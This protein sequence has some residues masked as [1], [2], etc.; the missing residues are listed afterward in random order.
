MSIAKKKQP[1]RLADEAAE[2][3]LA[4]WLSS[5]D[6]FGRHPTTVKVIYRKPVFWLGP[7]QQKCFLLQYAMPDG[8]RFVG[9][10]G[11]T[12][13][14][15]KGIPFTAIEAMF[16][17]TVNPTLLNIYAAW[18]LRNR[19]ISRHPE[20]GVVSPERLAQVKATLNSAKRHVPVN[21]ELVDYLKVKSREH[22]V[23]SGDLVYD[24]LHDAPIDDYENVSVEAHDGRPTHHGER[25]LYFHTTGRD[26]GR[27]SR[28]RPGV[29]PH[30]PLLHWLGRTY[31]PLEIGYKLG[32]GSS[33]RVRPA[34]KTRL[35]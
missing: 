3:A 32:G 22:F 13:G 20:R 26:F 9:I 6:G 27:M 24:R 21:L 31:G 33:V 35:A 23:L 2:Q 30:V 29:E 8:H 15:L 4:D 16:K 14:S 10:A 28:N 18:D 12:V 7:D 25:D 1:A 19:L 34:P 11:P 5:P 17:R